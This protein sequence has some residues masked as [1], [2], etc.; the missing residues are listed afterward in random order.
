LLNSISVTL[1]DGTVKALFRKLAELKEEVRVNRQQITDLAKALKGPSRG[2]SAP[3]LPR[4]VLLP[5]QTFPQVEKLE[6]RLRTES[7]VRAQMVLA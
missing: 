7:A 3:I 1:D 2:N 4:D 6:K 5:L